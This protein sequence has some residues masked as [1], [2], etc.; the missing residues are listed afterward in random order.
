[1]I[2]LLDL[3]HADARALLATGVPV[4]M[5]VNPVE[6]HGPHLSLH[7]DRL[8]TAGLARDFAARRGEE[9]VVLDDLEIGVEPCPGPGTRRTLLPVARS[10]V[11][12]ACRALVELG[13]RR[14]VLGTF[15]GAPLH[16]TAIEEG[17]TLLR[18]AGVHALAPFNL[19]VSE[20]V[21]EGDPAR[22]DEAVA[23]LEPSDRRAVLDGLALDFHAGFFETSVALHYAPQSVSP[24][25]RNLA[26][27][28]PV[29]AKRR[30]T[31]ASRAAKS[32]GAASL[33]RDLAFAAVGVGWHAMRPF[34]G[35]T[36]RPH[37]ASAASGAV[38]AR[39]IV[40]RYVSCAARVLEGREASPAPIMA[41]SA[42][43]SFGGRI[44]LGA[45]ARIDEMLFP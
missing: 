32:L 13:A 37:L 7:N 2:R 30:F 6:Y 16:A 36:G 45:P 4:H 28:P 9:L 10:L 29:R 34:P 24:I 20:L 43:A 12:E 27:C 3:P 41:W 14:V 23:H 5:S 31:L 40:D 35:Y 11:R 44:G 17:V 38:F 33:A 22:F 19:V 42:A 21:E 25:Y 39:L 8:V 1:M 18:A 15:H 26:P